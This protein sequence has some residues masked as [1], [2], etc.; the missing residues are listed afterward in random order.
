MQ[1]ELIKR[2]IKTHAIISTEQFT[3]FYQNNFTIVRPVQSNLNHSRS[4]K[5]IPKEEKK[6]TATS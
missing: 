6:K 4:L 2:L 3:V 5:P 1:N